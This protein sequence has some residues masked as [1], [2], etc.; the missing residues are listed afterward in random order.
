[1]PN[2]IRILILVDNF[3]APEIFGGH[4]NIIIDVAGD[5]LVMWAHWGSHIMRIE[6]SMGHAMYKLNDIPIFDNVNGFVNCQVLT[7]RPFH[8]PPIIHILDSE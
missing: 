3:Y 5:F 8:N 6:G 1:M 2:T 7:I 4:A